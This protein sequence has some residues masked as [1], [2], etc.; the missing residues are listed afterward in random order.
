M[1]KTPAQKTAKIAAKAPRKATKA[2]PYDGSKPLEDQRQER[3]AQGLASGK[4][5]DQAYKLA[6]FKVNRGNASRL[7]SNDRVKSRVAFLLGKLAAR[8]IVTAESIA[9]QLDEDRALAHAVAQPGAAVSASTA[10]AKLF[11]LM[12]E[13]HELFGPGGSP[14]PASSTTVITT[15]DPSEAARIYQRMVNGK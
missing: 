8:A 9:V 4:T 14:L 2:E 12:S 11:G 10:K 15:T 6:G 13:K 5:G 3:Y 7:K 1:A